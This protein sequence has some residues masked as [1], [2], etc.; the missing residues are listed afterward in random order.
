VAE[1]RGQLIGA[2]RVERYEDRESID[3]TWSETYGPGV[4]GLIIYHEPD[5]LAVLVA[6]GDGRLDSYFGRFEVVAIRRE[7]SDIT[8]LLNHVI[9]A[10]SLSEL[11]AA[12]PERPFRLAGDMLILG[13]EKTWRRVCR[14]VG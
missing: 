11:L 8:G 3:D 14:R 12:D 4:D 2:W 7:G 1:L 10:S 6:D 5:W 9:V 13:D